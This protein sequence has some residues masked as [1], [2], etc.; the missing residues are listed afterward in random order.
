MK[1]LEIEIDELINN[2]EEPKLLWIRT[3]DVGIF[4]DKF[5]TLCDLFS[6]YNLPVLFA[7]IPTQL[8]QQTIDKLNNL[9]NYVISQHGYSHQNFSSSYQCELSDSR[10]LKKVITEMKEGKE[11]LLKTFGNDFYSVLTP[12]FNKID[13]ECTKLLKEEFDCVSIFANSTTSFKKDFNPN[14]DIIN[15]HIGGFENK[16][17]ILKQVKKAI[18]NFDHLGICIHC[19]YLN[20]ESF[21]I[22][23][24]VFSYLTSKNKLVTDFDIFRRNL[25]V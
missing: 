3:D 9:D 16:E 21:K 18:T 7:V 19:E 25:I 13:P 23:D 14:V 1:N 5:N 17:F 22:L 24:E 12:P 15:W 10:D 2:F 6:K 4:T 8:Q 20:E 11:L